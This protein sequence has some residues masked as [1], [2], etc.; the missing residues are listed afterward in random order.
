MLIKNTF[1]VL[2]VLMTLAFCFESCLPRCTKY[3]IKLDKPEVTEEEIEP[4]EEEPDTLPP[5]KK[6]LDGLGKVGAPGYRRPK[7]EPEKDEPVKRKEKRFGYPYKACKV[8]M[9]HMHD[10]R[11]Y[12]GVAYTRRQN[13]QIGQRF[14]FF[15]KI[16]HQKDPNKPEVGVAKK[17]EKS[18]FLF[19]LFKKKE[20][21]GEDEKKSEK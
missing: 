7:E 3:R 1:V 14:R 4:A 21:Q 19:R 5:P 10:G 8:R 12:R 2:L 13:L 6:G 16:K 15:P 20:Q 11:P 18:F 17:S 9:K